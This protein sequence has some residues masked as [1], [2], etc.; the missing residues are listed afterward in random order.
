MDGKSPVYLLLGA[1]ELFGIP[2]L[3]PSAILHRYDQPISSN[4]HVIRTL[5]GEVSRAAHGSTP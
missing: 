4:A 3:E 5:P 1:D 2:S